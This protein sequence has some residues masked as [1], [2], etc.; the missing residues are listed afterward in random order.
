MNLYTISLP[1][2]AKPTNSDCQIQ[3][4]KP[5]SL[6]CWTLKIMIPVHIASHII[7]EEFLLEWKGFQ[8]LP[9][10]WWGASQVQFF[11]FAMSQSDW[12]SLKKQWNCGCS[13]KQKVLV[14][15]RVSS[16]WP[17]YI[18]ER[19]ITF[20][21]TIWDKSE[22]LWRTCW[23]TYR[24]PDWNSLGTWKEQKQGTS[25]T[26]CDCLWKMQKMRGKKWKRRKPKKK[27]KIKEKSRSKMNKKLG[28]SHFQKTI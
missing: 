8:P 22:V 18:G 16:L 17:M 14:K 12:P 13:P 3:Q 20:A 26:M 9:F 7:Y 23:G 11:I 6:F 19:R 27:P 24:E 5:T 21:K 15:C 28:Q 2:K 10:F 4:S 1:T 25:S